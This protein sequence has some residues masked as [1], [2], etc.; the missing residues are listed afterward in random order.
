MNS[1]EYTTRSRNG[2]RRIVGDNYVEDKENQQVY[3][4]TTSQ[5]DVIYNG[6]FSWLNDILLCQIRFGRRSCLNEAVGYRY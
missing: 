3:H 4:L 6:A 1:Q 5:Q 2:Q